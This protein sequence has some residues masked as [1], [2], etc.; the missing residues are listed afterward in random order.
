[1]A[2]ASEEVQAEEKIS[3]PFLCQ[4]TRV[5]EERSGATLEGKMSR[6]RPGA[7]ILSTLGE[8]G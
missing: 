4:G 3:G 6:S 2:G 8:A 1:M 7:D 5:L